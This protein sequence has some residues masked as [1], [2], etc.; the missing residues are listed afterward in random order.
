LLSVDGDALVDQV[1]KVDAVQLPAE[2][3]K[4]AAMEHGLAPHALADAELDQEIGHPLLQEPR[5][6]PMLDVV[7][8]AVLDDDRIDS[9]A[10]QH[11]RQPEPG[12]TGARGPDLGAHVVSSPDSLP[13]RMSRRPNSCLPDRNP[14]RALAERCARRPRAPAYREAAPAEG[15]EAG[16]AWMN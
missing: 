9:G 3:E 16:N 8:A 10:A 2:V 4:D 13:P 15:T 1:A 11:Q 5:P 12:R 14:G 6:D 7:A